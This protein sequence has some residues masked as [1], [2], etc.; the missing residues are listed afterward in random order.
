VCY[1]IRLYTYS[2]PLVGPWTWSRVPCV[3]SDKVR[4]KN[5]H[6]ALVPSRKHIG[7]AQIGRVTAARCRCK[8]LLLL[9]RTEG[10][11]MLSSLY[12]AHRRFQCWQIGA[13]GGEREPERCLPQGNSA[14]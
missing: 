12:D 10:G 11:V 3:E 9:H 5:S 6:E 4:A 8:L 1:N 14:R 2:M 7:S 13:R